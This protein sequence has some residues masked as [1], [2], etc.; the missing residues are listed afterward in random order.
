L[1]SENNDTVSSQEQRLVQPTSTTSRWTV[2]DLLEELGGIDPERVGMRPA[3]GT[4]TEQDVIEIE[5]R[6]SRLCELVDG[7]LVEK[8]MSFFESRVAAV[9]SYFL[10]K[11][12]ETH[13]PGIVVGA[14]GT[15]KLKPRMM[16]I[17]DVSFISWDQLPNRE[18]PAAP[19]V[20]VTN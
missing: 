4:A 17:P 3:P 15:L 12:L 19:G 16:R 20:K 7:V 9:L 1:V 8:V 18:I 11:Y 6:E 10:Q 13:D 14:D 5:N 2:A